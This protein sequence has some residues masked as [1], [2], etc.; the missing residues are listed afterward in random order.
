MTKT[1]AGVFPNPTFPND[2]NKVFREI[3]KQA[4]MY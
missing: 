4:N 3:G 1:D 2:A